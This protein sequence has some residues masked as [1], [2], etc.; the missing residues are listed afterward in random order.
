MKAWLLLLAAL[1]VGCGNRGVRGD[2]GGDGQ[3]DED[4]PYADVSPSLGSPLSLPVRG[5]FVEEDLPIDLT[6]SDP[7]AEL[8]Q[9]ELDDA[10]VTLT[11]DAAGS[12]FALGEIVA[13]EEGYVDTWLVLPEGVPPGQHVLRFEIDGQAAGEARAVLLPVDHPDVVVRSDVDMTYLETDFQSAAGIFD[14]LESDARER[15]ALPGMPAVYRALRAGADG[16]AARPVVFLSGSPR[17]FKRT[18]E[19]RMLLDGVVHAGLVL[20]PFKDIIGAGLADLG[21]SDIVGELEEQVGYKLTNLLALRLDIPPQV[22]EVL[23]GD[24]TE[25]DVVVYVLYHRFTSGQLTVEELGAAL[26]EMAVSDGWQEEIDAL[27][28]AVAAHLDGAAAPVRAIYINATDEASADY[29][30]ADWLEGGLVRHHRTAWPLV[31]DL[32]EQGWVSADGVVAVRS[33]LEERGVDAA[34]RA[35][36]VAEAGFVEAGTVDR[37]AE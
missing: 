16:A 6:D 23:M 25:A 22:P 31:L 30:V 3:C 35:A 10:R 32:F 13:D 36:A 7:Y 26:D 12:V 4:C 14:L 29:P 21:E 28:P 8:A 11:L 33:A 17:F 24:D 37:F 15:V 1:V 5:R 20:K 2:E 34:A 9:D 19:G 27:A 18:I